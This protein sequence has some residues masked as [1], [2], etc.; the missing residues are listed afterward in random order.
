VRNEGDCL[1][2]GIRRALKAGHGGFFKLERG[3]NVKDRE[4]K[5]RREPV[6]Q[7]A[8]REMKQDMAMGWEL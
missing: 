1:I 3:E 8:A 7:P 4:V 6:W 5:E 2:K